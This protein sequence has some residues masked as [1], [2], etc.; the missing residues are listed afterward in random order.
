MEEILKEHCRALEERIDS[1]LDKTKQDV[2]DIQSD[3]SELNSRLE[4]RH[5]R[6]KTNLI[7]SAILFFFASGLTLYISIKSDALDRV[8]AAVNKKLN[9][10]INIREKRLST[11]LAD[12]EKRVKK[13]Q[14]TIDEA[15]AQLAGIKESTKQMRFEMLKIQ[16]ELDGTEL[17]KYKAVKEQIAIFTSSVEELVRKLS[18]DPDFANSVLEKAGVLEDNSIIVFHREKCPE[19]GWVQS[20]FASNF[21]DGTI[22]CEKI[23]KS[24]IVTEASTN[25]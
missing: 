2:R 12:E 1:G 10:E 18:I 19:S 9:D 3:L 16:E 21:G 15:R 5:L 11:S 17:L 7:I 8:D 25:D 4:E 6:W 24:K 14:A 20:N 22:V 13:A 23:T